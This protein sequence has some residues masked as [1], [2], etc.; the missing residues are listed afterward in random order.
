MKGKREDVLTVDG[1]AARGSSYDTSRA[2][3]GSRPLAQGMDARSLR[4]AANVA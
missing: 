1:L 3:S 2:T 4:S